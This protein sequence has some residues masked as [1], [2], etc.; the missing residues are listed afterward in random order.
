M[1]MSRRAELPD[2]WVGGEIVQ[3]VAYD[4]PIPGFATRRRTKPL[5]TARFTTRAAPKYGG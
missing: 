5:E 2:R 3:A 4:N 1:A